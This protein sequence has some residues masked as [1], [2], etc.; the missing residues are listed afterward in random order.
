MKRDPLSSGAQNVPK[1][2]KSVERFEEEVFDTAKDEAEYIT[3]ISAKMKATKPPFQSDESNILSSKISAASGTEKEKEK[4]VSAEWQAQIYQKVQKT[5]NKYCT[6]LNILY[7][8]LSKRFEQFQSIPE[9][10]KTP[11]MIKCEH[12]MRALEYTFAVFKAN[13]RE[14]TS[15]FEQRVDK[16]EKYIQIIEQ[17]K[18][19]TSKSKISQVGETSAEK[20]EDASAKKPITHVLDLHH[21]TS[22]PPQ[23][24]IK[25][26]GFENVEQEETGGETSPVINSSE[27]HENCS[28]VKENF[29]DHSSISDDSSPAMQHLIKVLT[30]ISAEALVASCGEIGMIFHLSDDK[31]TLEPLNGPPIGEIDSN[32]DG[33]IVT[34]SQARYL[35]RS[36]FGPRETKMNRFVNAM[37]IGDNFME[38]T[39]SDE[40]FSSNSSI[41]QENYTLSEE[42]KEINKQLIDTEIV[43]DT[44]KI[45]P[46]T[47]EEQIAPGEGLTVKLFFNSVTVNLNPMSK[48]DFHKKPIINPLWLHI[49]I[50]YP[51]RSILILDEIA[52][53]ASKDLED[54][55]IKAKL[56]LKLSLKMLSQPLSLKDIAMSWDHCARETICEYAQLHG[57]GTFT[58]KYGGWENCLHDS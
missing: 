25:Q 8:G 47:I 33:V 27:I 23:E 57:G 43:I 42:I 16:M 19:V 24:Y 35:T 58:S 32:S 3:R 14:I 22:H 45:F 36:K 50:S 13:K 21:I 51:N 49:P 41:I 34:D 18:I 55:S 1:L 31:S 44:S 26:P 17:H 53:E 28:K 6:K 40:H 4:E 46:A 9:Q 15:D 39:S 52:S 38:A 2:M 37:T 7:K 48:H 11:D 29:E 56:K 5:K 30:S 54:L 20:V 10:P 12:H